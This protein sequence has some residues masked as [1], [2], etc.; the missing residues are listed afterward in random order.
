MFG[1]KPAISILRVENGGKQVSQKNIGPVQHLRRISSQKTI[2][3]LSHH[4]LKSH[5]IS[6]LDYQSAATALNTALASA[7]IQMA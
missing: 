7:H 4:N 2:S 5:K 1:K 3:V 6:L